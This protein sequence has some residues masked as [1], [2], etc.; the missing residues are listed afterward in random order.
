MW[1]R[2]FVNVDSKRILT[3]SATQKILARPRLA[4]IVPGPA[5]YQV[6]VW[7]PPVRLERLAKL[8]FDQ[9]RQALST[10]PAVLIRHSKRFAGWHPA[11]RTPAVK[12]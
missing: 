7:M 2:T 11:F 3:A 8:A 5:G 6:R 10:T 9:I 12:R 4:A 1:L